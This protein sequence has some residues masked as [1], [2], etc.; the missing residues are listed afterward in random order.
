[1]IC[2][3]GVFSTDYF[4]L[5][6]YTNKEYHR[7]Y[8]RAWTDNSIVMLSSP[9]YCY[10][11]DDIQSIIKTYKNTY[12]TLIYR[13]NPRSRTVESDHIYLKNGVATKQDIDSMASWFFTY[14][15]D[16]NN[17][18]RYEY[19][20]F[21]VVNTE[22]GEVSGHKTTDS[23]N[24]DTY[25]FLNY[26]TP[27]YDADNFFISYSSDN[28]PSSLE[29][30]TINSSNYT[31][32]PKY[33]DFA[34][35][36]V[37]VF[38]NSTTTINNL[39]FIN[40]STPLML[41]ING[42][43]ESELKRQMSNL[44]PATHADD[45]NIELVNEVAWMKGYPIGAGGKTILLK[46]TTNIDTT[47]MN[48][49]NIVA[50]S[51]TVANLNKETIPYNGYNKSSIENS[52]YVSYGDYSDGDNITVY[53]GDTYN[54]VFTYNALHNWYDSEYKRC[55]KMGTVYA[56]P[57]ETD[58]DIQAQYG[59]MYGVE[60]FTDYR[61]QDI[62]CAFSDYT[63]SKGSY[64]YNPAY[65]ATPDIV[66]WTTPEILETKQD[67]F[68][69]RIHYSNVKTNNEDIDSWTQFQAANYIDVDSRYGE[70][71]DLKLFKDKLIFWQE[72]ATGILAVNERVVLNDQ[73]DT[74]VVLGT[75]GVLERYDYFTTIYG[76]K[77]NQHARAISNDALYWWDSNNKEILGYQQKY[78][79][80]PLSTSKNVKNY[81]NKYE[82][83][84]IPFVG[85]DNKYKEVLFNVVNNESLVYNEQVQAFTSVYKFS[86]VFGGTIDGDTIFTSKNE[87]YLHNT[88]S[89]DSCKLFDKDAFPMLSYVVNKEPVYTK[90]YD[91]QTLGGRFYGG[92]SDK[93]ES[94]PY[95]DKH[96]RDK[97]PL[98]YLEFD[99][100]TPLKQQANING[101]RI[102]NV[103]YDYRL[104]IP[105]NG[106]TAEFDP[107]KQYG[108]RMKGKFIQCDISSTSNNLDFSLQYVTTKF[109]MSWD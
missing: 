18:Y 26:F 1:M 84:L 19:S 49:S 97:G 57:V 8:N 3:P 61:I 56:I 2:T 68:D 70:I 41:D 96:T 106:E 9:E 27:I 44:N 109:R 32:S 101:D 24:T 22:P 79:V 105:R 107:A 40:W 5:E 103:E 104:T 80:V 34:K 12:L 51:I 93:D 54:R 39:Q 53:S 85:Y 62:A 76:Q 29:K 89:D 28:F 14:N 35:D 42:S 94:I 33:S 81:I 47:N 46:T 20:N 72:N 108:N 66:S 43:P 99:Y 6:D 88:P 92:G 48:I 91:I 21:S 45:S 60:Q 78:D 67:G 100:R 11:P 23:T 37:V 63:Q 30:F 73:N 75:G 58:I 64:L 16:S 98:T 83:S 13:T 31:D 87:L 15:K 36:G 7:H 52:S 50:P 38:K 69:T 4:H 25:W 71:T 102:E 86:P 95:G 74:Q 59:T 10:Q 90:T 17:K 82:E 77:K 55:Y 65:N